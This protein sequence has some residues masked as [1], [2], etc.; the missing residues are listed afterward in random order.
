MKFLIA[1]SLVSF[2][3]AASAVEGVSPR[4]A[5][6][7]AIDGLN[8]QCMMSEIGRLPNIKNLI[9]SGSY[10]MRARAPIQTMSAPGW[11]AIFCALEPVDTGIQGNE[12]EAP[13]VKFANGSSRNVDITPVSGKHT[14]LP[15]VWE[16]I[17]GI[18]S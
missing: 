2:L 7:I 10:T 1:L 16:L 17:I 5:I 18:G 14:H 15:C 4:K 11:S 3:I 9:D 8:S 13:W 12:W 6:I